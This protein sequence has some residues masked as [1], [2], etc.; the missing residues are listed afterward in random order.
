[1]QVSRR[2]TAYNIKHNLRRYRSRRNSRALDPLG[3]GAAEISES[4]VINILEYKIVENEN[5]NNTV[6]VEKFYQD[7]YLING[8]ND[9]DK[10]NV[11]IFQNRINMRFVADAAGVY[12]Q[13]EHRHIKAAG[14][15]GVV[16]YHWDEEKSTPVAEVDHPYDLYRFVKVTL[17]NKKETGFCQQ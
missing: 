11:L 6:A 9:A 10:F 17:L 16:E 4:P 14:D 1:M 5:R 7:S 15:S 8:C 3:Y 13:V 12:R 2:N